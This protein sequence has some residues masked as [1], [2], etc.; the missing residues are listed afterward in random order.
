M[1]RRSEIAVCSDPFEVLVPGLPWIGAQ[2]LLRSAEQQ[3]PG[4]FDVI[5]GEGM[6]VVPI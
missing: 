1:K 5:G 3:F 4:A 2:L 6:A